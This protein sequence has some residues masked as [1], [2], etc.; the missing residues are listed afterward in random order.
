M[1]AKGVEETSWSR[2]SSVAGETTGLTG[3]S[4][5]LSGADE[6]DERLAVAQTQDSADNGEANAS[7]SSRVSLLGELEL[8][9]GRSGASTPAEP[10]RAQTASRRAVSPEEPGRA[11]AAVRV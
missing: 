5:Q 4:R 11:L 8:P 1:H 6:V 3:I 9:A 2:E 10:G 7:T